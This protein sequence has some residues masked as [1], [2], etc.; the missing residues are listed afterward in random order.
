VKFTLPRPVCKLRNAAAS[1]RLRAWRSI[2]W[3]ILAAFLAAVSPAA[4]Q[5]E[6]PGVFEP[7]AL[8]LQVSDAYLGLLVNGEYQQNSTGANDSATYQ[9][10][11]I[12]PDVGLNA[13]GSIYH[14]NFINF[15][16]NGD[17]SPGYLT[18]K[19]NTAGNHGIHG[20]AV[21][22]NY[23]ADFTILQEK[24]YRANIYLDQTYSQQNDDFF[25]QVQVSTLRYGANLGYSTGPVPFTI[26]CW[27]DQQETYGGTDQNATEQ[28]T[29]LA[30]SASNKRATGETTLN[31]TY[32]EFNLS[33]IGGQ[34]NGIDQVVGLND[35]E[36]FGRNQQCQLNSAANYSANDES[37]DST[38]SL[39]VAEGLSIQHSPSL[40]SN[41]DVS[42]SHSTS[43]TSDGSTKTDALNGDI[44]LQHQLYDSLT[45]SL[46]LQGLYDSSVDNLPVN[47][48]SPVSNSSTKTEQVGGG[49]TE[50]YTKHIGAGARVSVTASVNYQRTIQSD[51][52]D[53]I[54][55]SNEAHKFST[56]TDSFFLNL[57][58]VD[59]T[60]IIITNDKGVLPAYQL[61]IDYIVTQNG[62]LT[63]IRRTATS[64]IPENSKVLVTYSAAAAPSG[65]YGTLAWVANLRVDFWNGLLGAYA[66]LD[67]VQNQG[68]PPGSSPVN[69]FQNNNAN[70]LVGVANVTDY[71]FGADSTWRWLRAGFEYENYDSTYS[72]YSSETLYQSLTFTPDKVSSLNLSFN[73]GRSQYLNT[74]STEEDYSAVAQ[75]HRSVGRNLSL[76]IEGGVELRHGAGE[77]E[78]QAVIRPKLEF[79]IGELRINVGYSFQY[80]K[81]QTSN[82]IK[83]QMLF[84]SARR[85]F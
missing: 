15:T 17:I 47:G 7:Q 76:G 16:L 63:M 56:N 67:L 62:S 55:Q 37:G 11:F 19:T 78:T 38:Q 34:G 61:V 79:S 26:D 57:P 84:I 69:S 22:G 2:A 30:A 71:A 36:T 41:Y 59:Q 70:T 58:D 31:Y 5:D 48:S 21:I 29:V 73:E 4:A 51:T 8:R 14:P 6:A 60:S 85:Y 52:G 72:S 80:S 50:E 82:I 43:D 75:Y 25:N 35:T 18:E 12:G 44:T 45:S 32:T 33:D 53:T 42:Y 74:N 66:R 83:D 3:A 20:F 39:D 77:D 28:E 54:I 49:L 24:P 13:N 68:A 65:Q 46:L 9:Y 64:N 23:L 27:R 40:W 81:F 1:G 10:L